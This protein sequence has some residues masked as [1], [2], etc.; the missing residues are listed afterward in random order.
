MTKTEEKDLAKGEALMSQ[1]ADLQ[2][3]WKAT[4]DTIKEKLDGYKQKMDEIEEQLIAIGE[5]KRHL[6]VDD[7]LKFKDGYLHIAS[8]SFVKLGKKFDLTTFFNAYPEWVDLKKA[9]KLAPIKKACENAGERKLI[10]ALHVEID[11]TESMKVIAKK[12]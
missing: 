6:F 5:S 10:K 12:E 9:L 2:E 4:A 1:Y 7:N 11:S 3:Q 8:S